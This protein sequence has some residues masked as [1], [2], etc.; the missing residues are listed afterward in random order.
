MDFWTKSLEDSCPVD[1]IYFDLAK[2]FDSVPHAHLLTKLEAYGL[3]EKLL[4]WLRSYLVGRRQKVVINGHSSTWCGVSSGVPQGSVLGPLLF[5][6]YVNDIAS[7]VNSTILQFA[8][9]LKMFRVIHDVTDFNQLQE[10][11]DS[12]VT[13][14]NKWQ[15][16]FNVSKCHLLHLGKLHYHGT[17]N[18]QGNLIPPS[19]SVKDL[20]VI[21]DDKLKFHDHVASVT[22]KANRTL[23]VI[24]INH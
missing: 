11:I 14:A 12:L 15:L 18:I 23:A 7:Q 8:D 5:N 9:D 4:G 21:I 22:A 16:Q 3:T 17:Y 6:I 19:E 20:G 10:D 24:Y 13:W 1:V 2:A